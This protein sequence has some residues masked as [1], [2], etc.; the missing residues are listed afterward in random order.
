MI[1]YIADPA[2]V[3]NGKPAP[4]I[5]I[6]A[7]EGIGLKIDEVIEWKILIQ[8][9]VQWKNK[10]ESIGIGVGCADYILK[11]TTDL[12]LEKVLDFFKR[13]VKWQEYNLKIF[14]K[15]MIMVSRQ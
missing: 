4:D 15:N 9:L 1:D 8:V 11:S 14:V 13:E 2:E 10:A 7:C 12:D 5:F 6:K 3:K